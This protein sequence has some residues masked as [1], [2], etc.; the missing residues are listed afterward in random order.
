MSFTQDAW[1]CDCWVCELG[2]KQ[3]AQPYA[4][5]YGG[6][7]IGQFWKWEHDVETFHPDVHIWMDGS[8]KI[9]SP[10]AEW[11]DYVETFGIPF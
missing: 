1:D 9:L 11:E 8:Q 5:R 10:W 6:S 2:R 4:E 3:E 7:E